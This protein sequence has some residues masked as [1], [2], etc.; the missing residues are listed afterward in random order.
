MSGVIHRHGR[1]A[2]ADRCP[3]DGPCGPRACP[4]FVAGARAHADELTCGIVEARE[5]IRE[6]I[7]V[8]GSSALAESSPLL[9]IWRDSEMASSHAVANHSISAEVYG[10][11]LLG[12]DE[13]MVI[14]L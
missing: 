7:A 9:R 11:V 5:A 6:L 3:G 10:R 4:P 1:S 14:P 12:S 13:P 2:G 8:A